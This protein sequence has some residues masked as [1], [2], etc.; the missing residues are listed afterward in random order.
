VAKA[1]GF[2]PPPSANEVDRLYYQ[3]V[4]IHTINATQLVEFAR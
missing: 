1:M 2:P 4:E 3:L